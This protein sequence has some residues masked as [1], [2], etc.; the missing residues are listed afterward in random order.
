MGSWGMWD[1]AEEY[2]IGLPVYLDLAFTLGQIDDEQ[3]V[4]MIRRHGADRVLFG[5][6]SPWRDQ[7]TALDHFLKLDLNEDEKSLILGENAARLLDL[8][9]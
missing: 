3:L 4:R 5:T 2:V 9:A 6:D 1:E 7:K 8:Q